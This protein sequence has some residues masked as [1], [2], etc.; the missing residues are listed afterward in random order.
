MGPICCFEGTT[1]PRLCPPEWIAFR[2]LLRCSVLVVQ[3]FT[4]LDVSR[5]E[6]FRGNS[7]PERYSQIQLYLT[8]IVDRSP[9]EKQ[10]VP[11]GACLCCSEQEARLIATSGSECKQLI[12]DTIA[13]RQLTSCL[14]PGRKASCEVDTKLV[15]WLIKPADN[16]ERRQAIRAISDIKGI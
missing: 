12:V 13:V 14:T 7:L 1:L 4:T 2:V 15:K 5:T 8:S 6:W 3:C 9:D 11:L 16:P 10:G